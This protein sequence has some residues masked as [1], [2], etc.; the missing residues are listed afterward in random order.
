MMET[1]VFVRHKYFFL[2]FECMNTLRRPFTQS[3]PVIVGC[4]CLGNLLRAD[5]SKLE[6]N[7][8]FLPPGYSTIKPAPKRQV[9]Q[10]ESPLARDMEFRG[11]VQLDG[12]YHFSL[13]KKS[14]NK[15]YWIP[16]NGLENGIEVSSF[17]ADSMQVTVTVSGRSE[18]LTLMAASED[19]LP[20]VA[21]PP[22]PDLTANAPQLP[23]NFQLPNKISQ[24]QAPTRRTIPRR[25]VIIP[26]K[27]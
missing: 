3:L 2:K 23:P 18:Q 12:T 26:S 17:D 9:Q 4:L 21:K 11:V 25:R 22:F 1:A 27:R 6:S 19:P 24:N 16:E 7:S 15:G 13:F 8:P 10:P 20:V 14:E 5:T